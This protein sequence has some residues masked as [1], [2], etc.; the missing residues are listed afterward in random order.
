MQRS[1]NQ[2][3]HAKNLRV[4]V[5]NIKNTQR[6][7]NHFRRLPLHGFTLVELLVVISI[8]ALLVSI[9]MPALGRAREQA[10]SVEC[11]SNLHRIALSVVFYSDDNDDQMMFTLFNGQ[12]W[13]D[14]LYVTEDDENAF[15][16]PGSSEKRTRFHCPSEPAHG[17]GTELPLRAPYQNSWVPGGDYGLN[18]GYASQPMCGQQDN[19]GNVTMKSAKLSSIRRPAERFMIVDSE[20]YFAD[21]IMYWMRNP[22]M[23]PGRTWAI[24]SRHN[25]RRGETDSGLIGYI[26]EVQ[27]KPN[28]AFVDGHAERRIEEMPGWGRDTAPW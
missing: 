22:I 24:D 10:R 20:H 13:M 4:E 14:Y 7:S 28:M 26:S 11:L 6:H 12:T 5:T 27:G 17:I 15:V 25:G 18:R 9:L 21:S 3:T 8:I 2:S 19:F 16:L 23:I 1:C